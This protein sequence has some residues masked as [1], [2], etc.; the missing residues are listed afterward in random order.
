MFVYIWSTVNMTN[1]GR[2]ISYYLKYYRLL[3]VY[4]KKHFFLDKYIY[5][6]FSW[7]PQNC[8]LSNTFFMVCRIT[9]LLMCWIVMTQRI[10]IDRPK[11][12]KKDEFLLMS[13]HWWIEYGPVSTPNKIDHLFPWSIWCVSGLNSNSTRFRLFFCWMT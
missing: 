9:H 7:S 13:F 11:S 3:Q 12:H 2:W 1:F 10:H 4:L 8:R 6:Y 5:F